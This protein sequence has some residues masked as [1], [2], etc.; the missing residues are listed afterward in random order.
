MQLTIYNKGGG[1]GFFL[2]DG[3]KEQDFVQRDSVILHGET[4]NP[5]DFT[6]LDGI[7]TKPLR[8]AGIMNDNGSKLMCFHNGEES[9]LFEN[10]DHY[11]QYYWL[12]E[13]RIGNIFSVGTFRDFHWRKNH[14]H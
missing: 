10:K 9:N 1:L 14:W 6:T 3:D 5:D 13:N 4:L 2:E 8:Y 7:F 11:Y 12:N